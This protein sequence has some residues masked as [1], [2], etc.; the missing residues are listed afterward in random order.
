MINAKFI[1]F[2]LF[3]A[4]SLIYF[5]NNGLSPHRQM[6][7]V[8]GEA[9]L[10]EE[11]T[12]KYVET[13]SSE[14]KTYYLL[15]FLFGNASLLAFNIIINAIDIYLVLTKRPDIAVMLNRF[16]NIP[17]SLIALVLCFWKPRNLK[18]YM[19]ISLL[20]SALVLCCL[21]IF[22]LV[23]MKDS[24]VYWGSMVLV[25]IAGLFGSSILSMMFSTA[26]QFSPEHAAYASS[27]CGCCGVVASALRI[28]TK[29]AVPNP[30]PLQNQITSTVYFFL[31]AL[32]LILT[33]VYY[34]WILKKDRYFAENI[35]PSE[36]STASVFT[37]E[38]AQ[39]VKVIWLHWLAIFVNFLITL[40]LFPG[41]MTGLPQKKPLGTWVPVVV[42]T[43]FCI[44]DW[45]GRY[46]PSRFM[47]PCEK[48]SWIPV[49]TR[50]LFFVIF[51]LSIQGVIDLG[52]PY[53]TF[54]WT[55]PFAVTNGYMATV[56]MIHGSNHSALNT[57]QRRAAGFL[58]SFANTGGI[59]VAMFL[60]Y[61]MPASKIA[62][63]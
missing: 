36:T 6:D 48:Y 10:I 2:T 37:K 5:D 49:Y 20:I 22:I 50:L 25:I 58:M 4:A 42:T 31:A 35:N 61:A 46:L 51:M 57:D 29:A 41:Y 21:P 7:E 47:W 38:N 55:V 33:L 32:I 59:L 19:W 11:E 1:Q 9:P 40:T 8:V 45:A 52:E 27:G 15:Y 54:L 18:V 23:D 26:S 43:V 62:G 24:I 53:W 30:T 56:A 60:T 39:V 3:C 14:K 63:Q 13:G 44:F 28:I 34:T 17:S 12:N 16:Y